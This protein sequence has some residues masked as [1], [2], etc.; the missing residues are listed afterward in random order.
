MRWAI[1]EAFQ[2]AKNECGLGQYE[3]RR[4]TGWMRHI[5]LAIL[6][7][8]FLAVMAA[9]AAAKGAAETVPASRPSPWQKFGGFW[10]LSPHPSPFTSTSSA[11]AR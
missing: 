8:A 4:Y 11:H 7:H 5:T 10:Q 2:A 3:V 9:D 6:A 1:E